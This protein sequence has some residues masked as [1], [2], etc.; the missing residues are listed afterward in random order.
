MARASREK[1]LRQERCRSPAIAHMKLNNNVSR[2]NSLDRISQ[3]SSSVPPSPFLRKSNLNK[4][5]KM[6]K[7]HCFLK[8]FILAFIF[9]ERKE[10]ARILYIVGKGNSVV[11]SSLSGRPCGRFA[12][13]FLCKT[14][15][16][17]VYATGVQICAENYATFMHDIICFYFTVNDCES[18][19]SAEVWLFFIS[20]F[21]LLFSKVSGTT[22][23]TSFLWKTRMDEEPLDGDI[24]L[25]DCWRRGHLCG[26]TWISGKASILMR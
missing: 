24:C 8:I 6:L 12:P 25:R 15:N 10:R 14:S 2:K 7:F 3:T 9:R 26:T 23:V 1:E 21:C 4:G 22:M 16:A 19:S 11:S 18:R 13:V 17:C 20:S 5:N